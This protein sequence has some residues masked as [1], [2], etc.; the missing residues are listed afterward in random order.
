MFKGDCLGKSVFLYHYNPSGSGDVPAALPKKTVAVD[1]LA[2]R[3][4]WP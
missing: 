4:Y 1:Y 2:W 3:N